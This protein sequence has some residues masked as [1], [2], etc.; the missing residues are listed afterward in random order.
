MTKD[1]AL[2]HS[3]HRGIYWA[4][5]EVGYQSDQADPHALQRVF[6][7]PTGDL[8]IENGEKSLRITGECRWFWKNETPIAHETATITVHPILRRTD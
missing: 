2:D 7:R 5:P 4:W 1:F 3:H 6:L 8:N